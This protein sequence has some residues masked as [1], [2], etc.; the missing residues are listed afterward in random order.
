MK[1]SVCIPTFNSVTY[2]GNHIES[3]LA[4]KGVEFKVIVLSKASE[5]GSPGGS[6]S[7]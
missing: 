5:D 7:V 4:L 6:S 2:I 1:I 3:V